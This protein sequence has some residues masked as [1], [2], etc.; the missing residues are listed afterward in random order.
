LPFL[1]YAIR[2]NAGGLNLGPVKQYTQEIIQLQQAARKDGVTPALLNNIAAA[3]RAM[4]NKEG[5]AL[6][7]DSVL[8]IGGR[9]QL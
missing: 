9:V 3:Y 5:A 8:K 7:A 4:G 1:D 6:Y 2:N